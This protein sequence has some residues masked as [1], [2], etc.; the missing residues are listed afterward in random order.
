MGSA[1]INPGGPIREPFSPSPGPG[2]TAGPSP[3]EQQPPACAGVGTS[4]SLVALEVTIYPAAGATPYSLALSCEPDGGTV[5]D[6]AA[7]CAQLL[8]DPGLLE[9]QPVGHVVA[10]PMILA[11][12]ARAVVDGTYLG[13]QVDETIVDGG[14]DLQRWAELVQIFPS[15]GSDLQPVNPGGPVAPSH[16]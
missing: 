15:S 5:P 6:P 1:G 13:R 2:G 11:S 14:C 8:A 10:C 12:G 16:G 7:A 4:T 9:P 3:C